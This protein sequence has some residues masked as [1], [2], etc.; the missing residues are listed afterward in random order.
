M[1]KALGYIFFFVQYVVDFKFN[2]ALII[3]V[4]GKEQCEFDPH[5]CPCLVTAHFAVS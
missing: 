5:I 2:Y 4:H 1:L 3:P